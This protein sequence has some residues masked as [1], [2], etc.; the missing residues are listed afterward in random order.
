MQ[1]EQALPHAG[2]VER[3]AE[4]EESTVRVLGALSADGWRIF[5]DVRWPGRAQAS[6]DHIVVGPGGVFVVDS[7]AWSGEIQVKSGSL[8]QDGK[9][10]ARH[11]IASAAAAMAVG[12]LLPGLSPE[13]IR[14]VICVARQE[15]I[16][17]W[18][19]DTMICSTENITTFLTSS[20][21]VLDEAEMT[22]IAQAL[23]LSLQAAGARLPPSA[24]TYAGDAPLAAPS[25]EA[26][27]R[28]KRPP[29]PPMPRPV[30]IVAVIGALA[31][32][33]AVA[34]QLDLPARVGRLSADAAHRVVAPTKPIGTT[35]SV[36]GIAKRPSLE[37]TAGTP[38]VTR[39]KLPGVT[40]TPGNE[41]VAIPVSVHN[42]GDKDWASRSDVHAEL[43]D[44]SGATYSSDPAYTSVGTGQA[45]PAKV[46]LSPG[47]R[48]SGLVVFEV[49]RGVEVAKFRLRVGPGLP[50]ILRW[51]VG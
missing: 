51:S 29:R 33:A 49:P 28:A 6:I 18:C 34:F 44:S 17:G 50:A 9:R 38:A 48:T 4:E 25:R 47:E 7:Q 11:V 42:T 39:S 41:L 36:A 21:R 37:V 14:P 19:G 15:P 23:S 40:V 10:R 27:R 26:P 46:T 3:G 8:R 20:P 13:K 22:D 12:E 5:H 31:V 43:T 24:A 16:Y 2:A 45:L 35:V 30:R 1:A 32:A